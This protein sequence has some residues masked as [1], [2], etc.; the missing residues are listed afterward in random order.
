MLIWITP[1]IKICANFIF[2]L[3]ANHLDRTEEMFFRSFLF[4]LDIDLAL[5]PIAKYATEGSILLKLFFPIKI[6]AE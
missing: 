1:S 5:T 2:E 4:I 3:F 6:P